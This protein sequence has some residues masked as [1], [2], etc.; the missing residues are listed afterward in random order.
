MIVLS[1]DFV[2]IGIAMKLVEN[3]SIVQNFQ[4]KNNK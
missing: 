2:G 1:V 4:S 3:D